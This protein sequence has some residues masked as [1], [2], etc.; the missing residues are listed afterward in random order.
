MTSMA[1]A[2]SALQPLL[3]ASKI[4]HLLPAYLSF[5]YLVLPNLISSDSMQSGICV[6][7]SIAFIGMLISGISLP[8]C[9]MVVL[10]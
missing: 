2:L 3:M 10:D 9:P 8:L 1:A 4:I 7:A 6:Y 5:H